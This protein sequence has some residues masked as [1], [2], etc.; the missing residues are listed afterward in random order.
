MTDTRAP[1]PSPRIPLTPLELRLYVAAI[2]AAVY[3]VSWRAIAPDAA[4]PERS[5]GPGTPEESGPPAA[6]WLDELPAAQRPPLALPG[7]WRLASRTEAPAA[8][9]PRVVR[10]PASR[11]RRVR[12]RSS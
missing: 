5:A 6:V 11:P 9:A 8:P 4:S 12:T 10:A 7:G 2:L 3:L 1:R